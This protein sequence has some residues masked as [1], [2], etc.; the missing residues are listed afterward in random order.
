M[1]GYEVTV[2]EQCIDWAVSLPDDYISESELYREAFALS[3]QL[4]HPVYDI[5]YLILARRHHAQ[6]LSMDKKLLR[7][8]AECGVIR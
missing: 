6:L 8:A 2:C 4:K 7:L 3:C 1:A 5:L